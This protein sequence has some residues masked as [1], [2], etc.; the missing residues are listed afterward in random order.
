LMAIIE[1]LQ[2]AWG[3]ISRIIA[4]FAAFMAFL[5]AVKSGGAGPLFATVL[6][7][8]AVVLLDFVAN[9]L[10]KKLAS[11]ARKGGAK[12][13]GLAEKFKSKRRAKKNADDQR[14]KDEKERKKQEEKDRKNKEILA[15]AQRELP[16]KI[17]A[18]LQK[19]PGKLMFRARLAAW[20][21]RYRL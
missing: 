5:L 19:K 1:G 17:N 7:G 4:A 8:A 2:A 6:A 18:A 10:A 16:P 14:T 9:W 13:K 15:K 3:T 20:R 21:L 11:A 12:L